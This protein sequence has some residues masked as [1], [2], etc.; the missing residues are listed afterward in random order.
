MVAQL[1]LSVCLLGQGDGNAQQQRA[2]TAAEIEQAVA[3]LGSDSFQ[4]REAAC[5]LLWRAGRAA[6]DA[7][8]KATESEDPEV[9]YR[10]KQIYSRFEYGIFP[11]TPQDVIPLLHQFRDGNQAARESAF[12]KLVLQNRFD[13]AI[14]LLER[15]Q[16]EAARKRLAALVSKSVAKAVEPALLDGDTERARQWLRL[17][18]EQSDCRRDY[19]VFLLHQGEIGAAI[20]Q[21]TARE[22]GRTE[23]TVLAELLRA[24]GDLQAARAAAEQSGDRYLLEQILFLLGDWPAL[25]KHH[26]A[27][28]EDAEDP[29]SK[30][31]DNVAWAAAYYRLAGQDDAFQLT[32]DAIKRLPESDQSR[33]WYCAEVLLIVGRADDGIALLAK[34]RKAAAFELLVMKS[35]YEEAFALVGIEN[36]AGS[37]T[38]WIDGYAAQERYQ[39]K[40]K[41]QDIDIGM[42]VARALHGVGKKEEAQ[43]LIQLIHARLVPDSDGPAGSRE[44]D[45]GPGAALAAGRPA[46]ET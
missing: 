45:D 22:R 44:I 39:A 5:E 29:F 35:R 46:Q 25:A 28:L 8:R 19:A 24:Q 20:D 41:E 13:I 12:R 34:H 31:F 9:A 23:N 11:D 32:V 10:A 4:T 43:R 14:R 37:L 2:P 6:V 17:G 27:G 18:L 26:A 38:D 7:V 42:K 30:G 40:E 36:P 1:L 21:L 16:D 15:T 33:A 3:D